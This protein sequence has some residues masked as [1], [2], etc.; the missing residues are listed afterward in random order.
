MQSPTPSPAFTPRLCASPGSPALLLTL[1]VLWPCLA[2]SR[3]SVLWYSL[4]TWEDANQGRHVALSSVSKPKEARWVGAKAG[5]PALGYGH[6]HPDPAQLCW[7]R[8]RLQSV[9][10]THVLCAPTR[11]ETL[12]PILQQVGSAVWG[13][14]LCGHHVPSHLVGGPHRHRRGPLPP[15]LRDLQEAR[16]V[17]QAAPGVR[18]S[19]LALRL[20]S[21]ACPSAQ[22]EGL[23]QSLCSQGLPLVLSLIPPHGVRSPQEGAHSEP[24]PPPARHPGAWNCLLRSSLRRV[25]GL[26]VCVPDQGLPD[27]KAGRQSLDAGAGVSTHRQARIPGDSTLGVR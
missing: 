16:C 25:A 22:P 19:L 3:M 13:N 8:G 6:C 4:F 12:V 17:S 10:G 15:A 7:L 1:D 18:E 5:T 20:L 9:E 2:Q 23:S 11:V 26:L 27:R 14:H 21:P 24:T